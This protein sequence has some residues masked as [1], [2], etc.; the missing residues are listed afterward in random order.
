MYPMSKPRIILA[1]T[2]PRRKEL[3]TLL[4]FPFRAVESGHEENM[5]L[6]LP[7]KALARVLSRGKAEAVAKRFPRAVVLAADTFIVF[8]DHRLGKP[9]SPADARRMLKLLRGKTHSV[10][11]GYC[12][13]DGRAH[14]RIQGTVETRVLMDRYT[15]RDIRWY[16]STGEPLNKAGAYAIQGKGAVLIKKIDGDFFN[17]MGLPIFTIS[18]ALKKIGISH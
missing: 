18:K 16:I 12:L 13:I 6:P 15:D 9:R 17:V 3:L 2:S 10:I 1:S 8:R 5:A 11:T 4:G 14:R 7:P